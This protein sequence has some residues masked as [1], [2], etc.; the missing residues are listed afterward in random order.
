M[1]LHLFDI[2]RFS[3]QDGPG[4]RTT[5]FLKGCSMRCKWCHNP[6]SLEPK[7]NLLY[8]NEKCIGCRLCEEVCPF[9]VHRQQKGTHVLERNQCTLCGRCVDVCPQTA[10]EIAGYWMEQE[11]L[12]KKVRRDREFYKASG[13]G[14]TFSGGEPLLQTKALRAVLQQ[15]RADEIPT[16][17]ET[18]S[19]VSWESYEGLLEN[20]DLW[21]CDLKAVTPQLHWKGT[22]CYNDRILENL[23]R[24]SVQANSQIWIRVPLI[25]G[26]NDTLEETEKIADFIETLG[27]SVKRVEVM[28]YHDT[29]R[30]KYR[31]LGWEYPMGER[32]T[33][34]REDAAP[35]RKRLERK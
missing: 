9:H 14:V 6:E 21:I 29:G 32:K 31:A 5:V 25:P 34:T 10:L 18:C 27:P 22:G 23:T 8:Y 2:Q 17:I 7:E 30:T 12:L 26:F 15:L 3:V 19:H 28:S 35:F 4:I 13:G 33:M 11:E 16:A 1:K 24:L 20:T